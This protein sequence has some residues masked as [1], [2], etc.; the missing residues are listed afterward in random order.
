LG[1]H[2]ERWHMVLGSHSETWRWESFRASGYRVG[3]PKAK[4]LTLLASH[5]R[6]HDEVLKEE[7]LHKTREFLA[8]TGFQTVLYVPHYMTCFHARSHKTSDQMKIITQ[9]YVAVAVG[10]RGDSE[11]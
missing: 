2:Q 6:Q 7:R 1:E 4:R 8:P 11:L 9:G 5:H 10:E 3:V